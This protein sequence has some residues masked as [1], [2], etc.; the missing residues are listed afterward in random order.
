MV[1]APGPA[2]LR[3]LRLIFHTTT[4]GLRLR[5]GDGFSGEGG[6]EGLADVVLR[7]G[8]VGGIGG[9]DA[10]DGAGV[11]NFTFFIDDEH[12][13]RGFGAVLLANFSGGIEEDGGGGGVLVLGVDIGLGAGAMALLAGGG[14]DNGKPDHA[15]R[16]VLL[17][18]LLHIAAGVVLFHERAFV[19]EPFENDEFAAEVGQFVGS[20]LGVGEGE[21]RGGFAGFN[22]GKGEMIEGEGKE[23]KKN[24]DFHHSKIPWNVGWSSGSGSKKPVESGRRE[25]E[26]ANNSG[27]GVRGHVREC[28]CE[29]ERGFW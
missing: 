11:N 4:V 22:G 13:G 16:G 17:L 18:E 5:C 6:I 20:A 24:E 25:V 8:D 28:E 10:I 3:E 1:W 27:F 9:L 15:F 26:K 7:L 23:G 19:I 14:G 29:G 12:F 21:F 2:T